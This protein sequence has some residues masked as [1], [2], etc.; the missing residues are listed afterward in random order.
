MQQTMDEFTDYLA[1]I[2]EKVDDVLRAQKDAV[3]ARI[4]GVGFVIAEAMTIRVNTAG[5][6][7]GITWSKVHGHGTAGTIARN[8]GYVLRQRSIERHKME[9]RPER[10]E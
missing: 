4:I 10:S 7:R 9:R 8:P 5:A 1:T 3:L 6:R 2:D